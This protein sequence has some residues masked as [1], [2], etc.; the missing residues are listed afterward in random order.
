VIGADPG[1]RGALT[2][3]LHLDGTADSAQVKT[4]LTATGVHRAE[5]SPAA[6]MD[7]DANCGFTYHYP[8]RAVEKLVCDSPLGDGHIRLGANCRAREL[9]QNIGGTG[10]D[11]GSG[12]L[13][14]SADGA[15]RVWAGS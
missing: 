11:S 6:P 9:R 8:S 10:Q 15:Q 1:W 4:R 13:G 3:E 14:C 2:G 12:R 5:F 7:F